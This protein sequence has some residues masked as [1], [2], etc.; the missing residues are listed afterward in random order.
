VKVQNW[1]KTI[2]AIPTHAFITGS[3]KNW[4]GMSRS[5]SRRIKR[6]IQID[7]ASIRFLEEEEVERFSRFALLRDYVAAKR[8][9]IAEFNAESGR[10]PSLNADIR[11]LTNVG[12][13][14]AYLLSYLRNHPQIRQDRTLMVR[15]LA[16]GPQGLP[17]EVYCFSGDI[18]WANYEGIQSD[19]F[20]HFLAI[21]P[22][23]GLRI[24][25]SPSGADIS[26]LSREGT[27]PEG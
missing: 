1:D 8:G 27:T 11:R 9:E 7:L 4:R 3:F 25:Q 26:S 23:F 18:V 5:N 14:R 24:F 12:T 13:F 19:I 10:N 21:A 15:Q 16:P 2:T 22:E 20:D 17:L 6:A